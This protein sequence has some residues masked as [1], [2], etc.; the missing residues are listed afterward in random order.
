ME[1]KICTKTVNRK[2]VVRALTDK[3]FRKMLQ[4][5]PAKALKKKKLSKIEN[6]EVEMVL[7]VI[8]GIDK[9]I[10][11]LADELLCANGG[12]GCGIA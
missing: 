4:E 1:K 8:K 10:S 5:K 6:K 12:G 7:A 11:S 2:M 9:Q 3:K